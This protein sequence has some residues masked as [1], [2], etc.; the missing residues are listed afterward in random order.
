LTQG[1][2]SLL[3]PRETPRREQ[4]IRARVFKERNLVDYI[5]WNDLDAHELHRKVTELLQRPE[6]YQK[7][8]T[9]FQMNAYEV[10]HRRL[11]VFQEQPL[12]H[13]SGGYL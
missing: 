4:L 5:A 10:M 12:H 1:T 13:A 8:I 2:V 9:S 3:I 6:P 11:S 7:A